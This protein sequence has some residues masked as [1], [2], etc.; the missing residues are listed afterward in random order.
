M[1]QCPGGSRRSVGRPRTR[2]SRVVPLRDALP[3]MEGDLRPIERAHRPDGGPRL[4]S[5]GRRPRRVPI[6]ANR[7]CS[8]PARSRGPREHGAPALQLRGLPL[9]F[10]DGDLASNPRDA[11]SGE[12]REEDRSQGSPHRERERRF[13]RV[14]EGI[15]RDPGATRPRRSPRWRPASSSIWP[16]GAARGLEESASPRGDPS[17]EAEAGSPRGALTVA[18]RAGRSVLSA[19][20]A[21]C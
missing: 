17:I 16:G 18:S 11:R 6:P 9:C 7:T 2:R 21:L 20:R 12:R 4:G 19:P 15:T 3:T 10:Q 14:G 1:F 5:G 13:H 8:H